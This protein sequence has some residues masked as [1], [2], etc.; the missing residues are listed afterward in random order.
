M[1]MYG[2][3]RREINSNL[4]PLTPIFVDFIIFFSSIESKPG[5]I[6][7]SSLFL[8]NHVDISLS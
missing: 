5:G 4:H 1:K 2:N 6:L 7:F 8:I 3:K